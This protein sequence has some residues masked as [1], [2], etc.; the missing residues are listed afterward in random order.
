MASC[1]DDRGG[2]SSS[3]GARESACD[4]SRSKNV[5]S[6]ETVGSRESERLVSPAIWLWLATRCLQLTSTGH[7][8]SGST[9]DAVRGVDVTAFSIR[10][11]PSVEEQRAIAAVLSDLDAALE[12][13]GA[14]LEKARAIKQGMMQELLTGRTRL[15][16][17]EA[18]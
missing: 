13:L 15:V 16:A 18:S 7:L 9:F 14:K 4:T 3:R 6:G 1:S 17:A 8:S 5:P 10:M 11:P 12:A 2:A